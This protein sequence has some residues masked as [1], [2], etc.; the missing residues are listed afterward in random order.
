[1]YNKYDYFSVCG[2]KDNN[3]LLPRLLSHP[4]N[5]FRSDNYLLTILSLHMHNHQ[6]LCPAI[7]FCHFYQQSH[8][9]LI[10]SCLPVQ[11]WF[12]TNILINFVSWLYIFAINHTS[13]FPS[14]R[15]FASPDHEE[16][17]YHR[18]SSFIITLRQPLNIICL[19]ITYLPSTSFNFSSLTITWQC[20]LPPSHCTT[21]SVSMPKLRYV[22]YVGSSPWSLMSRSVTHDTHI[23][24]F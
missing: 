2:V 14:H 12:Y 17:P 11:T 10:F 3:S 9:P 7:I 8:Y 21:T 5:F 20:F 23:H 13:H 1:M 22:T 4:S 18:S 24:S 6:T 19:R 16:L 15:H